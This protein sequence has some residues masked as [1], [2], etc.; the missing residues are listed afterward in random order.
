VNIQE[1]II[2]QG[3]VALEERDEQL[4]FMELE[5]NELMRQ[6]ELMRAQQPVKRQIENELVDLQ[7][8]RFLH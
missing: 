4:K 8:L 7:V 3:M 2:R 6:I 1:S 5:R